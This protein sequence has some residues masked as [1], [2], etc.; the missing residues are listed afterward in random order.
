MKKSY[1][2][3]TDSMFGVFDLLAFDLKPLD[4]DVLDGGIGFF[5]A[6]P[7]HD[8]RS[9]VVDFDVFDVDPVDASALLARF[10]PFFVV[11]DGEVDE[12]VVFRILA[13]VA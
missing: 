5:A 9:L 6:H 12:E 4:R 7:R 11:G 1:L 13:V 8:G 3:V 2:Y 10:G